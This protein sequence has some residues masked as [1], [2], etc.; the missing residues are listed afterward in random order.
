MWERTVLLITLPD[1]VMET[2]E[3]IFRVQ[4][5]ASDE[6]L[7][8]VSQPGLIRLSVGGQYLSLRLTRWGWQSCWSC[9]AW[10]PAR[11]WPGLPPP[12]PTPWS[13]ATGRA[14]RPSPW[15]SVTGAPCWGRVDGSVCGVQERGVA[16]QRTS[17]ESVVPAWSVATT[18]G[19]NTDQHQSLHYKVQRLQLFSFIRF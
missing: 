12:P 13:G 10:S 19:V 2:R 1:I 16:V 18:G 5:P 15:R 3:I 8:D 6:I 11:S 17:T 14:R 4:G 9:W 7:R